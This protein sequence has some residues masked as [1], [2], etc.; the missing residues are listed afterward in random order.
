MN[1]NTK[2]TFNE[3]TYE[4]KLSLGKDEK[5]DAYFIYKIYINGELKSNWILQEDKDGTYDLYCKSSYCQITIKDFSLG[6]VVR[7]INY[8]H[9]REG[10]NLLYGLVE[11]PNNFDETFSHLLNNK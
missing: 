1:N 2:L 11:N 9:E 6:E 3:T 10:E 4:L 7:V 5:N 8:I